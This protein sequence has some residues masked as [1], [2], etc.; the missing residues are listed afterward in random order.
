MKLC[1]VNRTGGECIKKGEDKKPRIDE[2][3][4]TGC[5]ICPNKCPLEAI[6]IVN[7][8]EALKEDPIHRYGEN[9]F[10]L[11][12]LPI[13]QKGKV[14]GLIGRNGIGKTTALDILSGNIIPNLG[15]MGSEDKA[16]LI[17]R[18]STS[19]LG[20]F[21]KDLYAKKIKLAYKPQ[22]VEQIPESFDGKVIDLLKKVD[23]KGKL[24]EIAEELEID[25]I[26]ESNIKE[27]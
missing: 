8:P 17:Q 19:P 25:K 4:C 3:M 20:A 23:E 5:G 2:T 9:S 24:Q 13:P 21:F 11:F 16:A 22:R 10:Q 15:K 26:L 7:L 14:I 18:Y 12:H 6:D 27:I 1:P